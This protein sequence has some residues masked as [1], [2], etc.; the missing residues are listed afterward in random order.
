[1]TT[2]PINLH[3]RSPGAGL[4]PD[5]LLFTT[6]EAAEL[7]RVGRTT[8][9]ALIRSDELRPVHIGRCC[10]ISRGELDRYVARLDTNSPHA[11]VLMPL[12]GQ[13]DTGERCS[14]GGSPQD[15]A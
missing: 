9:Y 1:M 12:S 5:Q 2:Q 4:A 3:E 13:P 6:E 15:A 11:Q 7:L 8:V 10:R 14:S